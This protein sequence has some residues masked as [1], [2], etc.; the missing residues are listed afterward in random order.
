MRKWLFNLIA[1]YIYHTPP[2]PGRGL[3]GKLA[4][5]IY[6]HEFI[7]EIALGIKMKVR[8]DNP[9]DIMVWTWR[10]GFSDRSE[11]LF[12]SL[13]QKG[14]IVFDIGANVGLYT[15]LAALKVGPNGKIYA[16]EPVPSI[17][18]R[19]KE[20]LELNNIYNVVPIPIAVSDKK[21]IARISVAGMG[22]SLVY[23]PVHASGFVEVPT[24]P[25]DT[26]VE[27]EDIKRVDA[28]KL[29]VEGAELHVI[30]GADQTIRKFKP[31]MMVEI[32]PM[33]LKAAGTTPEE[34]FQTVIG[35]GYQAY[36]IRNGKAVPVTQPIKARW[37]GF[38]V[39]FDDYLF[40]PI[41]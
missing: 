40:L 33:T 25:L 35:Y 1:A 20:N 15:L 30:R 4:W 22:S 16:F 8:L 13:L 5:R 39:C 41:C 17:F 2:H 11:E 21:G 7:A 14:M 29:D 32:N 10:R 28:I 36:I 37:R 31:I 9:D 26:F 24:E 38:K 6:P 23:Y 3:L 34:L 12:V 27:Q 18:K 19:L